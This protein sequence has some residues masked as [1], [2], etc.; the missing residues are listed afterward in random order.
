[1]TTKRPHQPEIVYPT[2]VSFKTEGEIKTFSDTQN[3]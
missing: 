3:L 1:M 2:K